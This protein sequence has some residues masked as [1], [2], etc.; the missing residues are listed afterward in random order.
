M[1]F[2]FFIDYD[3]L[4]KNHKDSGILKLVTAAL[5]QAPVNHT[6][7]GSCHVRLYGGWYEGP[8][9]SRLA[10][11]VAVSIQDEF[12]RVIRL[13]RNGHI[14]G[15]STN[16]ELAFALLEEPTH[17]LF[18][19]YRKKGKPGNI[20]VCSPEDVGCQENSCPLPH[21]KKLLKTGKC[22]MQAC[23]TT[24]TDLVYRHEQKIVDTM[25]TCD[26]IYATQLNYDYIILI[27]DD[28][29]FLP[30]IRTAL[31]RGAAVIRIHPKTSYNRA[32]FP[33]GGA[34]FREMA[35]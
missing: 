20:R 34:Q 5:I 16:V 9:M 13:P 28:D 12:P 30:S 18:N 22:P 15:L 6:S 27:S 33:M 2:A 1:N 26:L 24:A 3:N 32:S 31:L 23:T 8:Y 25:L 35:I 19:T 11:D 21:T 10:Q 7:L 14:V 29:D 4:P 17:H